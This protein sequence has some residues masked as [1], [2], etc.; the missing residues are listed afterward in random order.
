MGRKECMSFS[1]ESMTDAEVV[2][3]FADETDPRSRAAVAEQFGR[4]PMEKPT[5]VGTLKAVVLEAATHIDVTDPRSVYGARAL[6]ELATN[7]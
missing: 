5:P 4:I 7:L 2:A 3:H 1:P 6:E